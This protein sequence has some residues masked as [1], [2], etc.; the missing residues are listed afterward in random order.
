MAWAGFGAGGP[1]GREAEILRSELY[2]GAAGKVAE[3]A[4][5]PEAKVN[6]VEAIPEK[7]LTPADYLEQERQAQFKSEYLDGR[8][9]AMAGASERHNLLAANLIV[10][11]GSQLR[12]KPCRVYPSDLKIRVGSRFFYPDVSVICG[13]CDFYE[14]SNDVVQNPTVIV[15]VLSESTMGYDRGAKFMSYQKISS[16]QDYLLVYQD[17][18]L[19]EH[20]SR[21]SEKA[22]LYTH[23]A[24]TDSFVSLPSIDC[25]VQLLDIY[26]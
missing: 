11:L 13:P 23:I 4:L 3:R 5:L 15:E 20:Y 22:W 9:L 2:S 16:L 24:G 17:E 19:V 10:S 1:L 21:H 12:G 14:A 6:W 8:T 18:P 7:T 25:S 26:S